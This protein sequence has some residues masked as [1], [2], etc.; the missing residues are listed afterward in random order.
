ML[1]MLNRLTPR[2]LSAF[3]STLL[4]HPN[5]ANV[6]AA[7]RPSAAGLVGM[8]SSMRE[9]AVV[10]LAALL[11]L[12]RSRGGPESHQVTCGRVLATLLFTNS[13]K[14][15]SN[16]SSSSRSATPSLSTVRQ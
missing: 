9:A 4:H 12:V 16:R 13:T 3:V 7:P 14:R 15:A 8:V 2:Y 6:G 5:P 1:K 11:T 10:A